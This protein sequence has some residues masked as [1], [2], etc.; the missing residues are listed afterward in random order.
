MDYKYY[1]YDCFESKKHIMNVAAENEIIASENTVGAKADRPL[2]LI[3]S[4]GRIFK[5]EAATDVT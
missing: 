2:K 5:T 1:S 3:C 4:N